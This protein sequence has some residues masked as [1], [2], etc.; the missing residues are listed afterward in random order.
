MPQKK[1]LS[2]QLLKEKGSISETYCAAG[3]SNMT[4][5]LNQTGMLATNMHWFSKDKT[6]P[7]KWI[8]FVRIHRKYFLTVKKPALC[9]THFDDIVVLIWWGWK[10]VKER[11]GFSLLV[12][13]RSSAMFI[14]QV[15][16]IF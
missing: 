6:L 2:R 7:Q 10:L 1:R 15:R 16:Y 11:V 13:R 8:R 5:C 12:A 14:K 3:N 4:N 9:C